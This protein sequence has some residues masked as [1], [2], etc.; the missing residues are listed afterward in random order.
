V[1]RTPSELGIDALQ[2]GLA[3]GRW[4]AVEV[5][6]HHLRRIEAFGPQLRCIQHVLRD[7]ED[8]A[9]ALDALPPAQRGSLHGV[10]VA[11]KDNIDVAGVPTTGG[12]AALGSLVPTADAEVVRRL[13]DAGAVVLAKTT[14]SELA[15]GSWDTEGSSFD[16]PTAN[17]HDPAYACGGSS[18]GSA[19]A[20]AAGLATVALGTDTGCSV[21]APAAVCGVVGVRPTLDRVPMRGV[22]PLCA[23]WDTVGPLARSVADARRVL[24][25]LRGGEPAAIPS[26]SKRVGVPRQLVPADDLDPGVRAVF[27]RALQALAEH[28]VAVVDPAPV[29]PLAPFSVVE[30]YR[31]ASYDLDAFLRGAGGLSVA[32]I[33]ASGSLLARY[34]PVLEELVAEGRPPS[35]DPDRPARLAERARA[36]QQLENA[37]DAAN[38]DGLVFPTFRHPPVRNGD[39]TSPKSSANF[40]APM[41]GLPALCVPMG[42]SEAGL[43]LG[44]Q[45]MGR[46]GD[47]DRLLALAS[48]AEAALEP[49]PSPPCFGRRSK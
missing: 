15:W 46:A 7:A 49:V 39:R 3:Q 16:G 10:P 36:R 42:R 5:V 48:L 32:E 37:M 34:Q 33:V 21:R 40:W 19:V 22:M 25:V 13:R 12:C 17:P 2:A 6:Q 28:G 27:C 44:L 26:L 31:R 23:D 14:M 38:L 24:D 8:R 43:P 45:V 9:R 4:S 18:G 20:V 47:E 1:N 11:V 30:W 35:D 29:D 41:A